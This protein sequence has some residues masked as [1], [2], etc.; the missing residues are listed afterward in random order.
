MS[1][2]VRPFS[3]VWYVCELRL[4]ELAGEYCGR[5]TAWVRLL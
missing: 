5:D 3:Y 2:D 1:V 4:S